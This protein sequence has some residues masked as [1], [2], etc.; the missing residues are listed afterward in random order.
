M[1][2][3]DRLQSMGTQS[4][5]NPAGSTNQHP[6]GHQ[7]VFSTTVATIRRCSRAVDDSG[8]IPARFVSP[9]HFDFL[10]SVILAG[11]QLAA[12]SIGASDERYKEAK[13]LFG[14]PVTW[15]CAKG[16]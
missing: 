8:A 15:G 14:L 13:K 10:S 5:F 16:K 9:G 11:W 1:E 12:P 2:M 3:T 7:S 6:A 4:D